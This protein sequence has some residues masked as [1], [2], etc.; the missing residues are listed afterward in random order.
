MPVLAVLY[1]PHRLPRGHA[2]TVISLSW[3]V[4]A[5]MPKG[6]ELEATGAGEHL[7]AGSLAPAFP[8]SEG[9]FILPRL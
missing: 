3:L 9:R 1:G 7:N 8:C 4:N 5:V 2:S 6:P